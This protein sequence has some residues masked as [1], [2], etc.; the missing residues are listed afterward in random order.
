METS[1][2]SGLTYNTG[3]LPYTKCISHSKEVH[4]LQWHDIATPRLPQLKKI[5]Q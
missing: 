4:Q 1:F 3:A 5:L 2:M